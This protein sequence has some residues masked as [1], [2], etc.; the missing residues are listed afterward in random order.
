[1]TQQVLHIAA[2]L[3]MSST[4]KIAAQKFGLQY[5][6]IT[7]PQMLAAKLAG[8]TVCA[9][10]IDL[11]TPGLDLSE[12]SQHMASIAAPRP[13]VWMYAQHVNEAAL[14]QAKSLNLGVVMT[15]GQF[16]RDVEKII[17]NLV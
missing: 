10:L 3:M 17:Q 2:D 9:L 4:V 8:E 13:G 14:D 7:N 16:N 11:Q 12:I 5:S 15:R 1:M 6:S